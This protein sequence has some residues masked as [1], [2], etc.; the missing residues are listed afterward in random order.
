MLFIPCLDTCA[1]VVLSGLRVFDPVIPVKVGVV[2]M[3]VL[4][5]MILVFSVY[6]SLTRIAFK[7]VDC[8]P[9]VGVS[10]VR[11]D[12]FCKG[13]VVSLN[14]KLF[15][16]RSFVGVVVSVLKKPCNVD[17]RLFVPADDISFV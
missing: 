4:E 14:L 9:S 7:S 10:V 8:E 6:L 3:L 12:A 1:V 11:L 16:V 5:S 17:V 2:R 13:F 15:D